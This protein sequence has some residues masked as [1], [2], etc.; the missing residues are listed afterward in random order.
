MERSYIIVIISFW[1][2]WRH[3][4]NISPITFLIH[5]QCSKNSVTVKVTNR[6]LHKLKDGNWKYSRLVSKLFFHPVTKILT[7][8]YIQEEDSLGEDRHG[9]R[10][11]VLSI[12]TTKS[13]WWRLH[14]KLNKQIED[15]NRWRH[16]NPLC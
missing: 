11:Q 16:D 6:I 5:L 2:L 4:H 10:H 12:I 8:L 3:T 9:H 7:Y 15:L 1:K 14:T 13:I